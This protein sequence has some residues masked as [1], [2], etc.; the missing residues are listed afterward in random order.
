MNR[1]EALTALGGAAVAWP[2]AAAAQS[3][4]RRIGVI[5]GFPEQDQQ[6]RLGVQAL[7]EGLWRVGLE[8][9]RNLRIDFRWPGIDADKSRTFL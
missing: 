2:K 5:L 4:R 1:R 6:T 8:E 9:P 7:V 3:E